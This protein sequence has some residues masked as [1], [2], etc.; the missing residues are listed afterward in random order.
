MPVDQQRPAVRHP[1]TLLLLSL[2]SD[3]HSLRA[4]ESNL[5]PSQQLFPLPPTALFAWQ[6]HTVP[7]FQGRISGGY[8]INQPPPTKLGTRLDTDGEKPGISAPTMAPHYWFI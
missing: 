2:L 5:S 1:C 8:L 3:L 4:P 7:P 6:T